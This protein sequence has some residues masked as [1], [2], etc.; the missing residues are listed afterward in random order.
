M[1]IIL[2]QALR[3]AIPGWS[4][5][6]S[7]LLKD[8]AVTYALGVAELMARAHHVASRTYQHLVLYLCAGFI[9]MILTF[10]G[11]RALNALHRRVKLRGY[12]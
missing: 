3:L 4:N 2:P 9:F 11:T 12:S 6:Y 7:V 10:L 8:S 5:E 1:H